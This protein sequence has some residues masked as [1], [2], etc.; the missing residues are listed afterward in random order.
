M[1]GGPLTEGHAEPEMLRQLRSAGVATKPTVRMAK[2]YCMETRLSDRDTET[3]DA[4]ETVLD[5][6][7]RIPVRKAMHYAFSSPCVKQPVEQSTLK[8]QGASRWQKE[9]LAWEEITKELSP[10]VISNMD[11]AGAS[12][13]SEVVHKPKIMSKPKRVSVDAVAMNETC[14]NDVTDQGNHLFGDEVDADVCS[15][16]AEV[17]NLNEEFLNLCNFVNDQSFVNDIR[18][19]VTSLLVV[20]K[21]STS[22]KHFGQNNSLKCIKSNM[23]E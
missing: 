13:Y 15:V 7:D 21:V 19:P 11:M 6:S 20:P 8:V 5:D 2:K 17:S 23:R 12:V 9:S 18:V 14:V 22:S 16:Q 4:I 10:T 3:V 1:V